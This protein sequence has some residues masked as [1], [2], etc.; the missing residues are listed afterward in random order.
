MQ[1]KEVY[2]FN[3]ILTPLM[4]LNTYNT[5]AIK[6]NRIVIIINITDINN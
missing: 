4:I 3:N 2:F 6:K 5:R 1:I